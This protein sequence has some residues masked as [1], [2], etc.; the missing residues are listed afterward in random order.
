MAPPNLCRQARAHIKEAALNRQRYLTHLRTDPELA[1]NALFWCALHLVQAHAV[2]E[3]T[4]L[5]D[6]R[7]PENHGER[8]D[9]IRRRL[10]S[11]QDAYEI[12]E[13]ASKDA[14]YDLVKRQ[15]EEVEAFYR[16]R[17]E[18]IRVYLKTRGIELPDLVV[19]TPAAGVTASSPTAGSPDA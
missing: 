2:Q 7:V 14:R 3:A 15:P 19:V 5:R 16:D 18:P 8:F 13:N 10:K 12:L 11:I 17:F 1:I 9:H 4:R 6:G